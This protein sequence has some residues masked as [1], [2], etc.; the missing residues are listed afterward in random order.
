MKQPYLYVDSSALVKLVIREPGSVELRDLVQGR[1]LVAS[2]IALVEFPR[3]IRRTPATAI[4]DRLLVTTLSGLA[5][6]VM[7]EAVLE[8]AASLKPPQLRTLDAIH[9]AS[10]L[11]IRRDLEAFVTYDRQLGQAAR[12]QGLPVASPGL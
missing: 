8:L 7:S 11:R 5:V 1:E 2:E 3:A 12:D 4:R 10:A 9:L 6:I